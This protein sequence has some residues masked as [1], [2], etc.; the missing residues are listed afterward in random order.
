MIPFH[1]LADQAWQYELIEELQKILPFTLSKE[2][3]PV[4]VKQQGNGIQVTKKDKV[5]QITVGDRN[6]LARAWYLMLR[7][8]SLNEYDIKE[9]CSFRDLGV[10]L[11]CSRNAVMKLPTLLEYIQQ[12]AI[13]GYHS[14][15][16]YTED[17]IKIEEEP[18]FG[19]MRGA[20]TKEE[21]K[22]VDAYCAKFGIEL[23]PCVQTL[24]H[25]NQITRYEHYQEII[26]VNDI[27]LV[28]NEKTYQLIER[29]IAT[30]SE[31]FTS[32]RINIG[33]DEAHMLGL[34]KFLDQNGYQNRFTIMVEH[35]KRVQEI[36]HR[37]GF[38]AMMWSDMFFRLLANGEYYSLKEEQLKSELL[39][40]VPKDI[41]LVY[42]DYYSRDYQHYA[43]NLATHY[44]I[45]DRI[46]FA[47]G[48]WKWTGFAPENS[49]S[50]VAGKEA[51]KA[52][53]EKGVNTF[54]VTCWGDNGAEASALSV[55]PT[56]FYYAELAYQYES[57]VDREFNIEKEYSEY[58]KLATGIS[59][60][61][62]MLL[63]SP[64]E[65]FKETTYT[66]SNACKFLLYNDVLIGTF[67]SIVKD[68]TRKAYKDKRNQLVAV[69]ETDTRYSYL[70]QTLSSLCH[71][72]EEKAD[73][74]VEIKKSYDKKDFDKL[75]EIA[76]SKIPEVLKRLDQF[77]RDFRYQW[78][79]ENK[80]FGFEIQ[81]IR[82][83]GLKERLYY[84][85]EQILLW[86]EGG[87][88]RIDELE[89]ERLPFAYFEQD[90]GS[91]LNY[92]LWNVIVSPAVM[93]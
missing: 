85:K 49:F 63:D 47:A 89:E 31:M 83:G 42:W 1:V 87:I 67:D 50:Q 73:L 25:I 14:L 92:N 79:K 56:L 43:E 20:Y 4:E 15:Q 35:L 86:T 16:L 74:G 46:G 6:Q 68:E 8:E 10:M 29:I 57:L 22:E 93:G 90:D 40:H 71:L 27:F 72:L 17:T 75:R 82:L 28:G 11:D 88:E 33:M 39:Q 77:I 13:F 44:R 34:G 80:S 53:V 65:V 78:H 81:L 66:H 76:E 45:S 54:L 7:N 23:V 37:Y 26:D 48:A 32:R 18:Y 69:A 60:A 9:Q 58:F 19:Y 36:L 51:M 59:F 2:G 55:L 64:N 5:R 12:L 84:A 3:L 38:T 62:F 41:E 52:C 61:E 30:A 21:M 24:A 70:F 91:R